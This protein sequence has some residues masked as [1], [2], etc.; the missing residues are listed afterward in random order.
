MGEIRI[1][2]PDDTRISL[3]GMQE[4]CIRTA[5]TEPVMSAIQPVANPPLQTESTG[6][7]TDT[8][9]LLR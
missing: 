4:I 5:S 2:G 1:V 8:N 6:T 7:D 9:T 3:S